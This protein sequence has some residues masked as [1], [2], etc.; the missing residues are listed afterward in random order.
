[1]KIILLGVMLVYLKRYYLSVYP[2]DTGK[3][4]PKEGGTSHRLFQPLSTKAGRNYAKKRLSQTL[5]AKLPAPVRTKKEVQSPVKG[6]SRSTGYPSIL[7]DRVSLHRQR[8]CF[9]KKRQ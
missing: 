8:R 7:L 5:C 4:F 3:A 9:A 2:E 1:M 6:V